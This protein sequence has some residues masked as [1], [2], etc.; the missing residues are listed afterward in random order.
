MFISTKHKCIFIHIPKTGGS[1]VHNTLIE[2]I[3]PEIG[4]THAEEGHYKLITARK[5]LKSHM[6]VP[7]VDDYFTFC[8][9]RNPWDRFV[10]AYNYLL[11][12]GSI[13]EDPVTGMDKK[14]RDNFISPYK[15][16]NDFVLM[17]SAGNKIYTK[18]LWQQH[19]VPQYKFILNAEN[20][21]ESVDYIGR[22]ENLSEEFD[23]ICKKIGIT[24]P[25]LKHLNNRPH[26]PYQSY[27]TDKTAEIIYNT[28]KQDIDYFNYDISS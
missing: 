18:L 2:K 26:K 25:K 28:Y 22:F 3:K 27:Y 14:D 6:L 16:F 17:N 9:V 19:F 21:L 10:S 11:T 24:T 12:G 1:S 8:F 13:N 15:T 23:I 20:N 4:V 7:Y 5:R